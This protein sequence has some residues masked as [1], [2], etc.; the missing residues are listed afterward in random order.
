[1]GVLK[2]KEATRFNRSCESNV[3]DVQCCPTD[4]AGEFRKEFAI[5]DTAKIAAA[6][7]LETGG[8]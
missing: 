6:V 1:M 2:A 3:A 5:S 8:L 4:A 7:H